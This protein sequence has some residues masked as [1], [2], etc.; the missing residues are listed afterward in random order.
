LAVT[1]E[2]SGEIYLDSNVF[3][4][5]MEGS[6]RY[7]RAV[8]ILLEKT[9]GRF[10][11][12]TSELTIG[13]CLIGAASP[14]L[15]ALYLDLLNDGETVRTWPITRSI[16]ESAAELGRELGVKL[17][18]AIHIATALVAGCTVF[19]SN[20]RRLRLPPELRKLDLRDLAAE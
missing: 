17:A 7:R 8:E 15:I 2:I 4:Y 10:V 20:D 6:D 12:T 16:I 19:V 13:E 1:V 5:A 18:D 14:Q 11:S 9:G 3:I